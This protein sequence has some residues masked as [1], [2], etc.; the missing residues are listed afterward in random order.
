MKLR[1]YRI[2]WLAFLLPLICTIAIIAQEASC[3]EIVSLALETTSEACDATGRNQVCYGNLSISATDFDGL[4]INDFAASGDIIDITDVSQLITAPLDEASG[5]WG[6]AI[7]TLQ[8][9][10]PDSL[11]GQNVTFVI[12]GDT[13]LETVDNAPDEFSA[14]MQAFSFST[15]IGRSVCQEVPEDGILV[16]TPEDVRVN[17][18][19]NGVEVELGSTAFLS[20]NEDNSQ[21]ITMLE[22]EA[23]I[24]QGD[25]SQIV[26]AGFAVDVMDDATIT[27]PEPF[28]AEAAAALPISLLPREIA[29]PVLLIA[30]EATAN[31]IDSGI[32]VEAGQSYAITAT[33]WTNLWPGC[34]DFCPANDEFSCTDLCPAGTVPVTDIVPAADPFMVMPGESYL[35]LLGRI[36]DGEPFVVGDE[37]IFTAENSGN[38]F[39]RIN[40]DTRVPGDEPGA[41]AVSVLPLE[42]E[43]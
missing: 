25:G 2:D 30:S 36:G 43:E 31:W 39:F 5:Q 15:G 37:L 4:T 20:S 27:E 24:L 26:E 7:M 13:T 19:V 41:Y 28:D 12:F 29:I 11:P 8:A 9:N 35:V 10:I 34:N 42:S 16:Q 17:F 21:T 23:E 22:G 3:P 14:P 6:V 33:G 1:K 18:L 32:A 40:E 38:L